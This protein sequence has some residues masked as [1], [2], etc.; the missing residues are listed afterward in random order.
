MKKMMVLSVCLLLLNA[1][2]QSIFKG[3]AV[4]ESKASS[5]KFKAE[6]LS[7]EKMDPKMRKFIEDRMNKMLEKTFE[8]SFD[9][10]AS[11]YKEQKKLDLNNE[12][13]SA[14]ISPDGINL[15]YYKN[16]KPKTA[17]VQK[18]L[19][20]KLFL[21]SDSLPALHWKLSSETKQIGAYLCRKATAIVPV[22][23][24]QTTEA[25]ESKSHLFDS[26]QKPLEITAWYAPEIPINQG[27]ERYWGLPGL[28]LEMNDGNLT[29]LCS[30][31]T[32]N[33]KDDAPVAA[34][35]SGKIVTQQQFNAIVKKK[36]KEI[37]ATGFRPGE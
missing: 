32:L 24:S 2:A 20:G 31:I 12:N 9:N 35:D 14:S 22:S 33:S 29:I 36:K 4:Y 6:V 1:N 21:V 25:N 27:P 11:L 7:D 19:M 5:E 30:K 23:S 37:E 16:I 26:Q 15:A 18:D 3:V 28:I 10:F 8:L 34:P 17:V 13:P